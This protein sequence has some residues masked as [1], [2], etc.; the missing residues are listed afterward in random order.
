MIVCE[1]PA[2]VAAL[3]ALEV[4]APVVAEDVPPVAL[5]VELPPVADAPEMDFDGVMLVFVEVT[6]GLDT[7]ADCDSAP[8]A[9]FDVEDVVVVTTG[10]DVALAPEIEPDSDPEVE[11]E[12]DCA[13]VVELS[14]SVLSATPA[15]NVFMI[16]HP[17]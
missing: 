14:R 8:A 10:L 13:N 9:E 7:A 12:V 3:L 2:L 15:H 17:F 4:E 6:V 16:V 11:V 5:D 1:F